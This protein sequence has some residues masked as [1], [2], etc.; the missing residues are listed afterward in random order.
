MILISNNIYDKRIDKYVL[1]IE[2]IQFYDIW[3]WL[4]EIL[5]CNWDIKIMFYV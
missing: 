5:L 1:N 2:L 4:L 3:L